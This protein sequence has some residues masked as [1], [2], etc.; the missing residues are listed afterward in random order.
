MIIIIWIDWEFPGDPWR[1]A[2]TR[3]KENFDALVTEFRTAVN[4]E[5]EASGK[6]RLLITSAVAADPKK[7]SNGY[8]VAN[9]CKQLDYVRD[10][11]GK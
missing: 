2:D 3:S 9:L 4:A 11:W 5:S 7:I 1:G 10:S 8:N 6:R